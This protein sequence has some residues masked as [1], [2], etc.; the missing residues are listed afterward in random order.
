[1][2]EDIINSKQSL[3]AYKAHLDM[4]FEKHKYLR[5]DM[6]KGKQRTPETS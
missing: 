6:K 1:M 4:M 2:A 5:M 3:D